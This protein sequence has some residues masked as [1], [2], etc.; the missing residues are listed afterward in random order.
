MMVE[1]LYL[2]TNSWRH[3]VLASGDERQ[4]AAPATLHL[5]TDFMHYFCIFALYKKSS[6]YK[7]QVFGCIIIKKRN[8]YPVKSIEKL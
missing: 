3:N 7:S 8:V 4:V 1:V 2:L 6:S 5:K